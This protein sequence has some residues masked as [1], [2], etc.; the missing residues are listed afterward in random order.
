M[1]C[2]ARGL[3]VLSELSVTALLCAI[4]SG[5]VWF[6]F[7]AEDQNAIEVAAGVSLSVAFLYSVIKINKYPYRVD[8]NPRFRLEDDEQVIER[9][10]RHMH[11]I[12][13][14]LSC[15]I[16]IILVFSL[17]YIVWFQA[18]IIGGFF[19]WIDK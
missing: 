14:P 18:Q 8:G 6:V 16:A 11:D 1:F 2:K 10:I 5:V 12:L 9:C 19:E 3:A 15:A 17:F 7:G 4:A 13:I